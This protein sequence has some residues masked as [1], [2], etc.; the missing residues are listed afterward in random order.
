MDYLTLKKQVLNKYFSRTNDMQKKAVFHIDGAVLIIAGA[1]SGKT[2]VLCNRIANMLL[3]GNAYNSDTVRTLSAD[4]EAFVNEYL[5]GERDNFIA[6]ERLSDIFGEDK[7]KPWNILAVTFTNK[8]AA[9][10]KE[11][12]ENMGADV[13]GIW[14]ATFHS[15]CVRILRQDIEELGMGYST[16]F[17]IYDTDDQLKVIKNILKEHNISD[18]TFPPKTVQNI[19]SRS[20]DKLITPEKFSVRGKNG[21]EDYALSTAK[22]VYADYQ[23]RLVAANALDFDDIIML[24]VKLFESCPEVL[25][26]WQNRFRYIM[27][28]EYQDTNAAQYKLISLLASEYGNLCVVGDEDQSIYRFR[29]ATVENILSFEEEFGAEVIKLE[30]NYRSTSNILKAANAVIANNTQHKEKN[31]WSDLGDGDKIRMDRFST[32]QEEAMFIADRI[33]DGIKQGK[34]YADHV[35]LYR[36]NAQ[37]RTVET[38]LAKS[39][40]PYKII[41][42]VRFYERKEIKDI[43]AYLCVLNNNF[44]EVR[45]ERIVNEPVRGIGA[46]TLD[47]IKNVASG[48]G[49]S[50]VQTMLESESFPSLSR[51]AKVLVPLGEAFNELSHH[52]DDISDG[53][54]IDE[55][56]DRFGYREALQRQGLEG[57]VRLENI[58]ELKSNMITYA[59]ENE[60]AGLSE[61]LEQVAL[62]SDMDSYEA[63]EDKAVLMTMHSAKGLEFDTV[64]AVGAEENIFPGYRAQFDPMEIEEERRLAY[65]AITRAK[66][67]LYFTCAKQRMLYGQTMRNKVSRF[68]VEIPS[69]FM[70]YNDHT[71][72]SAVTPAKIAEQRNQYGGYLSQQQNAYRAKQREIEKRAEN[73][74]YAPGE[75]VHHPVFGD[76]TIISSKAMGGDWL[77][78]IAFDEKG[79]KKVAAKFAKMSKI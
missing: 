9:E 2:T 51:K 39:G 8:A 3:F 69:E 60:G 42:G 56:L 28:D 10:L 1:G 47:E 64:F 48:M 67:H 50:F 70:S 19:I 68:V 46:A 62:V 36:N 27:V 53:S 66:R 43:S 14:A 5:S 54:L 33:L 29:G 45:F 65:V 59:K 38:A 58:N 21:N 32:E 55:I 73:A 77:L 75:R 35:V 15:A 74:T 4:D 79:T 49:I 18:K 17:T 11:R 12:L 72:V 26:R 44:D 52:T 20:K 40:I 13:N 25:L 37:S 22:T 24:T 16:N 30:Q 41:G 61:F 78:E 31:L 23:A 7:I 57:E 34:K 76:G 63:D 71:A 6:A